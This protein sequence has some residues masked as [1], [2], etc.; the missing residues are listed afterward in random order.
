MPS[1]GWSDAARAASLEVRRRRAAL[2]TEIVRGIG[3]VNKTLTVAALRGVAAKAM[4]NNR[5][6]FRGMGLAAKARNPMIYK[7]AEM[8]VR[9]RKR[10]MFLAMKKLHPMYTKGSSSKKAGFGVL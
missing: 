8:S 5:N 9:I 6:V 10:Q 4:R 3:G 2:N 1:K 7:T